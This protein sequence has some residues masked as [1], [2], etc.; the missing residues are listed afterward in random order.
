MSEK[1]VAVAGATGAVGTEM[2]KVL[3]ARNFPVKNIKMLASKRSVGKKLPFRGEEFPVEELTKKS[4]KGI[5]IA[6]FSAGKDRSIE[7]APAAVAA[8]TIVVDNSSAFR[9]RDDTPLVVP[10]VNPHRIKEHKGIIAN[11]NCSTIIAVVAVYPLHKAAGVK[12]MVVATYQAVSGTGA[13]A[14]IELDKQCRAYFAGEPIVK[15]VYPHQIAFNLLPHIGDFG[16]NGYSSEEMKMLNEGRKIMEHPKLRVSC[17]TIRVPVF[18]AHSEAINLELERPLSPEK[19]RKILSKAPGVKVV[20]DPQKCV[21]PMPLDATNQDDVLV[22]RI[23]R[24]TSIEHGLD[25]WI[26]GDQLLKGAALNAVQ[27]AEKLL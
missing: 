16:E 9:L 11:P 22:G 7:F 10:E 13:Q 12:R 3:E 25:I 23:R 14:I 8:G 26:S 17:T 21:Y 19:A 24:D 6:L 2:L 5:D 18:R 27:I 15:E 1:N 4:F 20:D